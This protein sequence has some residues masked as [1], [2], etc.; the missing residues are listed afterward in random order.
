M[1]SRLLRDRPAV[2]PEVDRL[3]RDP[4]LAVEPV[5]ARRALLLLP[6][7]RDPRLALLP[8]P[9]LSV[10]DELLSVRREPV[11][12]DRARG[13]WG[14]SVGWGSPPSGCPTGARPQLSQ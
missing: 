5:P 8:L 11:V 6:L 7:P 3:P 12:V 13:V 4:R 2:R 14:R 1:P 9:R 10:R